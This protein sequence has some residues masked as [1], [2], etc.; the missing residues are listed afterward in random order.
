VTLERVSSADDPRLHLFTGVRDTELLAGHGLFVA[1]SRAVITRALARPELRCRGLLLTDAALQALGEPAGV[2]ALLVER[3]LMSEVTGFNFHQGALGLFERPPPRP[4]DQ[5]LAAAAGRPLVVLD[6]VS[7]P[8]NVGSIFR[9]AAAFGAGGVL[10]LAGCADPLYRKA[11]RTSMGATLSLASAAVA[12]PPDTWAQ[13]LAAHGYAIAALTPN[14]P[15]VDLAS[16][17]TRGPVALCLGNEGAGLAPELLARAGMRLR[18]DIDPAVDS[19]GVAAA[20][21]IALHAVRPS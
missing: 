12:G 8:D 9:S 15:A 1:E 3:S 10:L 5:L 11:I 19:L 16:F 2:P 13:D 20:A 18:I 17:R 14:E 7:D 4:L 6:R 21:A